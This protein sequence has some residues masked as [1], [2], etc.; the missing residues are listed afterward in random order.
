MELSFCLE[1]LYPELSFMDKMSAIRESGIDCIEFWDYRAKDLEALEKARETDHLKVSNFSGNRLYGML[2]VNERGSFIQ[3]VT[4]SAKVAK[5]LRCPRLMLL[6]QPLQID[7]SAKALPHE[8][9]RREIIDEFVTCAHETSRLADEEN[10]DFVV[11]PLNTHLDHPGYFLSSS[12]LAF[13]C[14]K[15][16][17]HPRFKVLYDI[18]HMAMMDEPVLKDLE[19]NLDQIGYIHV[20]DKPG[21]MEPGT[22]HINFKEILSL[23]R[24]LD[25]NGTIGFE[26]MPSEA[27]SK[28]AIKKTLEQ[29]R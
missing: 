26:F 17:G 21:R 24:K 16:V 25:Y 9:S 12:K 13:E 4:A 3:E 5:R 10:M 28:N 27:G 11:E 23:L 8:L 14:I 6:A 2:N 18:Y 20:A 1:M 19:D 7:G 22:G 29:F 15:K